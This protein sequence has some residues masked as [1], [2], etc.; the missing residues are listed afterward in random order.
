WESF[1]STH[2]ILNGGTL[3][4]WPSHLARTTPAPPVLPPFLRGNSQAHLLSLSQKSVDRL[5]DVV[6]ALYLRRHQVLCRIETLVQLPQK[7]TT[8]VGAFHLAVAKEVYL[9]QQL[10]LQQRDA[11]VGGAARPVV[12][13][14]EVEPVDVPLLQ[15]ILL[16]DHLVEIVVGRGNHGPTAFPQ[17]VELLFIHFFRCGIV[18][19]V[20]RH[21]TL[22]LRS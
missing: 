1:T 10:L 5:V 3:F 19:N 14:R 4:S 21:Q 6:L 13:V 22:V 7:L 20:S 2:R 17:V 12:T 16:I 11:F 9:A 18:N 8:A 15:V